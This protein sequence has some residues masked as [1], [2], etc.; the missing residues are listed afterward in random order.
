MD[1]TYSYGALPSPHDYRDYP[2]AKVIPM[3]TY[4]KE[5]MPELL[6]IKN[7][8][9][10]GACVA[11]AL[12]T[13]KEYQEYKERGVYQEY[14]PAFIY[15]NRAPEHYQGEGMYPREALKQLQK[16]GVCRYNSLPGIKHYPQQKNLLTP[17]VFRDALPQKVK[18]YALVN[19]VEEVKNAVYRNGP[20]LIVIPVYSSFNLYT[21]FNPQFRPQQILDIPLPDEKLYGYHAMAIIGYTENYYIVQNSWDNT[22][23]HN[24]LCYMPFNYPITEKWA[25]TDLEAEHEKIILQIDQKV[26]VVNGKG[27]QMDVAPFIK[28]NRTFI[29]ARFVAEQLGATVQWDEKSRM[30]TIVKP[31]K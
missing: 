9:S 17:N 4:P 16:D 7:Q 10:V 6:K 1:F 21:P 20:V 28:D 3:G 30:I 19:T 23:G 12:S 11:F 27:I 29:P 31:I 8:G 5:Y 18:T 24:G 15:N 25:I 26:A 2:V 13:I 14:S 22:W